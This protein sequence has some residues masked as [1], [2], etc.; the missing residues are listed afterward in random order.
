MNPDGLAERL[1]ARLERGRAAAEARMLS[2]CTIRRDAGLAPQDP[3]TGRQPRDWEVIHA[4]LRCRL[5]G[6]E[7]R[8][9]AAA[10]GEV[11][12]P[13]RIL[14]VPWN[15]T[16]LADGDLIELTAGDAT[17]LVLRIVEIAGSDQ[18]T[19]LRLP[20]IGAQRPEEW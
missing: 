6:N 16:G 9:V 19:E 18:T 8:N 11:D 1:Q 4:D 15:T 13:A 3:E 5:T 12:V 7:A 20:V 14:R 17:G 10:G 2:R